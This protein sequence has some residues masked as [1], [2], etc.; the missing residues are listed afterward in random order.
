MASRVLLGLALM[1][2]PSAPPGQV[3]LTQYR[4]PRSTDFLQ[5]RPVADEYVHV[6]CAQ[7]RRM[8]TAT[9]RKA[10]SRAQH[11]HTHTYTH[12]SNSNNNDNGNTNNNDNVNN[13]AC[14]G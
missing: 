5:P 1:Q 2:G 9:T 6:S 11:T 3:W 8:A 4:E 12:N 14:E 13:V 10:G 7:E